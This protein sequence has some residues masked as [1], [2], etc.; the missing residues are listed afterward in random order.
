MCRA[1]RPR[2]YRG[3]RND[4]VARIRNRKLTWLDILRE[5]YGLVECAALAKHVNAG[6]ESV[7]GNCGRRFLL[8]LVRRLYEV[9]VSR[10][11]HGETQ[12]ASSVGTCLGEVI[13]GCHT[14]IWV[15]LL[16]KREIAFIEGILHRIIS[17]RRSEEH[18][19]ELQSRFD[20]VC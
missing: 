8:S 4:Q 11:V 16:I 3:P 5:C 1:F 18:T 10:R 15:H 20:L 2:F 19:S 9:D 14:S 12:D 13:S 7:L 6:Q 17:E